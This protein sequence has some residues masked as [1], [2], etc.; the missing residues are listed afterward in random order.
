VSRFYRKYHRKRSDEAMELLLQSVSPT[1]IRLATIYRSIEPDAN[2]PAFAA[3]MQRRLPKVRFSDEQIRKLYASYS[4][5]AYNL[6]DRGFLAHVHPLELWTVAYLRHHPQ[7]G[8]T[9]VINA[10]AEERQEVYTW[11]FNT[12]QKNTQDNR[13]RTMLEIEAFEEIHRAWQRLGYPFEALVPSYATAIGSSADRPAALAELMGILLNDGVRQPT[14][15]IR[16]LRFAAGTPY[17][18]ILQPEPAAGEQVLSPEIAA[19][20]RQELIDVVEQGTA[21]RMRS[22][23]QLPDGSTLAVGGKTGTGDNRYEIYHPETRS[24]SWLENRTAT[25]VFF[26]G[27]RFFGTLTVYV[28]GAEARLFSFTSALPVQ[29]LKI[30][31]PKLMPMVSAG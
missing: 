23:F 7:A 20:V 25:F 24:K 28:P 3:F 9:E 26:I 2:I 22:A 29:L 4:P 17:E 14:V 16:Q 30:L 12:Q 11:L 19:V 27:D 1:P 10:G 5:A 21:Q 15:R 6:A 18:T 8:L 13:I 31:A